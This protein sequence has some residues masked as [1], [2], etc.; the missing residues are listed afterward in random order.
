[1][2]YMAGARSTVGVRELRQNLSVHLARVKRGVTLTVTEHGH[3]VAILRPAPATGDLVDRL[4]A[5][6]RATPA[7]RPPASL[8]SPLRMKLKTSLGREIETLRDDTI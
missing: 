4:V 6:G 1:M 7:R 2:C 5:E 3:V 8:P